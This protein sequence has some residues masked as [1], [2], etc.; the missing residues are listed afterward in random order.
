MTHALSGGEDYEL[1]FC[2]APQQRKRIDTLGKQARVPIT[3][4][5]VCVPPAAGIR[6]LDAAGTEVRIK[7][8][9]HDHFKKQ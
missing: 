4:I 5:G 2:A 3:L 9:G 7:S 6:V 8:H 1:L